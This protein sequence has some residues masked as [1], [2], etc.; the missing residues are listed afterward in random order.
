MDIFKL[1]GIALSITALTVTVRK[2]KPELG[3][4]TALAGGAVLLAIG[5][6]E[7][8][9]LA[10]TVRSIMG[11]LGQDGGIT[12]LAFKVTGIA[13]M[14]QL[15]ADVCRDSGGGQKVFAQRR[16]PVSAKGDVVKPPQFFRRGVKRRMIKNQPL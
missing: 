13:Y 2:V 1:T 10:D 11:E 7:L 5:L 6:T 9:G 8:S 3:M 15:A 14:T 4:Q 16:F 12:E